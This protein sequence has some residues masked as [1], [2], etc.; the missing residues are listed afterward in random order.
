MAGPL[1][2]DRV[3]ETTTT[4][5]TGTINLD[6][7]SSGFRTF[8]AG[9]GTTNTC[10]YCI[11]HRSADEWEVGIGTVTD[12]S[13]DT[14]SRTTVLASSNSGS[15]VNFSAGTKDVF[16][17]DP[18]SN[19]PTAATQSEMEAASSTSVYVSPGRTKYHPGVAKAWCYVTLSGGTPTLAASHNVTSITDNGTG[20]Y[21]IN[22][23]TAF[24]S[25]SYASIFQSSNSDNT[26]TNNRIP[27]E[28]AARTKSTTQT[29]MLLGNSSD[30]RTDDHWSGAF[31]G[32]Q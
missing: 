23:T 12:A 9:I 29:H 15:L 21:S 6:G 3:K 8:V 27:V 20:D 19:R 18:A 32:D 7:T 5:G 30:T 22:F 25:A 11:S 28:N 24:S 1:L 16:N 26:T 10:F 2:A 31:Y 17:C 14:L 13:P 4:T